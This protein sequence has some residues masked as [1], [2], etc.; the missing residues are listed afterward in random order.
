LSKEFDSAIEIL[1]NRIRFAK[2]I[3]ESNEQDVNSLIR[4]TIGLQDYKTKQYKPNVVFVESREP[5]KLWGDKLTLLN[6]IANIIINAGEAAGD[7]TPEITIEVKKE[8]DS[9]VISIADKSGG[10]KQSLLCPDPAY[11]DEPDRL[12]LFN[13][14]QTTKESGTGLGTAETWEAIRMHNGTIRVQTNNIGS[15]FTIRLLITSREAP[16]PE[17]LPDP[18]GQINDIPAS[19]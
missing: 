18:A 11:P 13:P 1:D 15:T 10:I 16:I 7:N 6:A 12:L 14:K 3:I 17:R 4:E 9:L 2:G 19:L 5:I 8:G